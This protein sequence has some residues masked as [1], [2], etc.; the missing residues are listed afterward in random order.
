MIVKLLL[1]E[2][3]RKRVLALCKLIQRLQIYLTVATILQLI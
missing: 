2:T 3:S 1:N